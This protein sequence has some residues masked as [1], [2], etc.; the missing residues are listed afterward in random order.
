MTVR[1]AGPNS[2]TDFGPAS[3]VIFL[4]FG[5]A[6]IHYP[7]S[8]Y[9]A[10]DWF[11]LVPASGDNGSAAPDESVCRKIMETLYPIAETDEVYTLGIPEYGAVL[12]Y[13]WKNATEQC[14][15]AAP[16]I[17][18]H[19][20]RLPELPEHN[21]A[22]V[23]FKRAG[24]SGAPSTLIAVADGERLITANHY[25]TTDFGSAVYYLMEIL[26][27]SQMN[28]QQTLV[29]VRGDVTAEDSAMLEK[30][31]KECLIEN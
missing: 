11:T 22:I 15:S 3:S 9:K 17:Y 4:T 31:V 19:L 29:R 12:L 8:E 14:E 23:D 21:K 26:R 18:A 1:E 6:T 27:Q 20:R 2:P 16:E 24:N 28:P 13:A 10:T 30:Y 7:M 25:H 5:G